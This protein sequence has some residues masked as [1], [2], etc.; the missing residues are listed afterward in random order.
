MFKELVWYDGNGHYEIIEEV[1]DSDKLKD[2]LKDCREFVS[3]KINIGFKADD[4]EK[5]VEKELKNC[6]IISYEK[7]I[8]SETKG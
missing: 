4:F 1:V 8:N 3:E 5:D 2:L 7:S 6:Y